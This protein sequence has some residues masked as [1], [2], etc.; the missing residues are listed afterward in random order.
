[1]KD[2]TPSPEEL[3]NVH[4]GRIALLPSGHENKVVEH[5]I[6]MDQR[7]YGLRRQDIK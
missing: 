3:Q 4:L 7:Y 5:C 1:V 6:T 2:I